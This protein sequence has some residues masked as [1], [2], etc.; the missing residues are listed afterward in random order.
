MKVTFIRH[1]SLKEPFDN[2]DKLSFSEI[3]GLATGEIDPDIS[4]QARQN[5]EETLSNL[6]SV[7]KNSV[8]FYAS[9]R[10]AKQTAKIVQDLIKKKL[11]TKIKL[12]ELS[13]LN[14]IFFEPQKMISLKQYEEQGLSAIRNSM[15]K[16]LS[17]EKLIKGVENIDNV[18]QRIEALNKRLLKAEKK[19]DSVICVTH[20]F[21]MRV[22][23]LYFLYGIKN[24][25]EISKKSLFDMINFSN[26]CGFYFEIENGEN[27]SLVRNIRRIEAFKVIRDIP[28][29]ISSP[30][31]DSS[32]VTKNRM[33]AE[34]FQRLG[35]K[36]KFFQGNFTWESIGLPS[37]II[38]LA[39]NSH[40][41]RHIF[42]KI[43]VPEVAKDIVVDVTWNKKINHSIKPSNWT[44]FTDSNVAVDCFD[45]QELVVNNPEEI[46]KK[47]ITAEYR[48]FVN[49]INR[50]IE[51]EN[52]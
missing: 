17:A 39:P 37:D 35:Y 13:E 20:G 7:A 45:I 26:A 30:D 46:R 28:Y 47:P 8:I 19:F 48:K 5:I 43:Y 33:M 1:A 41:P 10:R 29:K 3:N 9:S 14:E 4:T 21:L 40:K 31:Q 36:V 27:M 52:G 15:F 6:N 44:G 38:K 49:E 25:G 22:L 32:C 2:Y 24:K 12:V 11:K 51:E 50:F 23:Q 42:M 18:L 34:I 16:H